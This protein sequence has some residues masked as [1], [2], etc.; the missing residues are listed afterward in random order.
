MSYLQNINSPEDLKKLSIDELPALCSELREFIISQLSTNPGHFG[1]S[2]GVIELTVALH[3]VYDTPYDNL[4]WDVGHQAYAH[5][6]L[7]GRASKF[8][9]NRKK[10]GLSGFPKRSESEYD[11]FGG[12][13]SSVSVSATLGMDIAANILDENRKSIAVIGDGAMSG[14]LAFEGLNNAGFSAKDM[15]VILNDNDMSIDPNVG[16][17][18]QYLIKITTSG[19]YNRFKNRVYRALLGRPKVINFFSKLLGALKLSLL[20]RGNLFESLNFRYFGVADGHNVK[21]LVKLLADLKAIEGPK[22]FHITT[23][24][25]KGFAPAEQEQT[26]WHAPGKYDPTT[27]DRKNSCS[28]NQ[29]FQDVFG[30]TLLELAKADKRIIG[31]TPAMPSGS[32]MS[33]MQREIPERVFDV[34]IAEG[35]AV[36]FSAGAAV[37]GLIPF[38]NIYSSFMQRAYDNVIHDVVFQGADVTLCLDRSGLVGEDGLTHHGIFDIAYFRPIPNIT[39]AAPRNEHKLRDLM[40]TASKGG[41]GAFVIRYP[42]GEGSLGEN[43]CND[44]QL[45][46]IGKSEKLRS[47]SDIAILSLGATAIDCQRAIDE[48]IEEKGGTISIEHIDLCFAKPL[49]TTM[50]LDI[51]ARFSKIITV[52]DGVISGGVGSSIIEFFND[53]DLSVKVKR[54]G[55]PDRFVHQGSVGELKSECGYDYEAIKKTLLELY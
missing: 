22:L 18:N 6:I 27:G 13:H 26:K 31:I 1:S 43:W 21:E 5:K 30:N 8:H 37:R 50:L 19:G 34:G 38:C 2:L 11:A 20:Q 35:H 28:A 44:M 52:E 47:G 40:F 33:I 42:R 51:A 39:I 46:E 9:T 41:C 36:T 10:A 55:V 25:G 4:V 29:K 53:N 49:D 48:I 3:Y 23:K 54:L 15:L 17:L 45:C 14:G 12:G 32:S 24:K 16:A 7:T